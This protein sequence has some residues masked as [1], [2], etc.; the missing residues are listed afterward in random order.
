MCAVVHLGTARESAEDSELGNRLNLDNMLYLGIFFGIPPEVELDKDMKSG[1][2][3]ANRF[4]TELSLHG[5]SKNL[6]TS[7]EYAS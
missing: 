6:S 4:T 2:P 3:G 5:F 1:S 7:G